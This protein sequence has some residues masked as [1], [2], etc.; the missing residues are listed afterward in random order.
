VT[1]SGSTPTGTG[2]V[3]VTGG[4]QDGSAKLVENADVATGAAIAVAKLASGTAGY[5]LTASGGTVVWAAPALP[6]DLN[7]AGEAQGDVLYFN[8]TNWVRLAPGTSGQFLKTFGVGA[9]PAWATASVAPPTGTGFV[10]ITAGSQD[11]AAK[12]VE[13]ADVATAAA[14]AVSKLAAGANTNVLTTTAGVPVWAAPALPTDLNIS[15]Q[16]QGDILYFNG[17]NWV[18]LAA[19]SASVTQFLKTQ[20]AGANPVWSPGATVPTGTG[21]IHITAGAEDAAAKLVVNADV[22]AAAAIAVSKL[23]AGTNAFVLTTTAG[24]PVWA[25]PALPTDLNISGQA[26]GDVLYFNGTNWVRLA[27][28]TSGQF[29]KTLGAGANPQWGTAATLDGSRIFL[30]NMAAQLGA[31]NGAGNFTTGQVFTVIGSGTIQCTGLKFYWVTTG[32]PFTI[33]CSLW[34]N[35]GTQLATVN[36]TVNATGVYTATFST[37]QTLNPGELYTLG[38]YN[39]TNYTRTTQATVNARYPAVPASVGGLVVVTSIRAFINGDA[40]PTNADLT[41][42]YVVDPVLTFA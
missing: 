30:T 23:A 12:L 17:T 31:T 5:V 16:A 25:A 15:G 38:L 4:V 2:F 37:P 40:K 9:D 27:A 22:D 24:V 26:Q 21:F 35:A 13:D 33:K 8:G 28:G 36:V 11:A 14:I 41:E 18:R 32:S 42:A 3:H 34:N 1:A 19:G 29:L 39:S 6:T 10:H 7:I 20:G